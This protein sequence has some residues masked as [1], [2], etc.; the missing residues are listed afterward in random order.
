[1]IKHGGSGPE[2]KLKQA[3]QNEN[4]DMA[5]E[6][7]IEE[8]IWVRI[9]ESIQIATMASD[10]TNPKNWDA[11][12]LDELFNQLITVVEKETSLVVVKSLEIFRDSVQERGILAGTV[13]FEIRKV[14]EGIEKNKMTRKEAVEKIR[15]WQEKLL[16]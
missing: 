4:F 6:I 7:L 2:N 3:L 15:I 8:K 10:M 9:D 5:I 13:M 1:M 11:L 12:E 14:M 16:S